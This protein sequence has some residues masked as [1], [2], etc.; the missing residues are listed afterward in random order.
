MFLDPIL[1]KEKYKIILF[2]IE[3]NTQKNNI[4]RI[5]KLNLLII[6]LL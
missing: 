5:L 1:K 6:I 4:P 3:V 2:K